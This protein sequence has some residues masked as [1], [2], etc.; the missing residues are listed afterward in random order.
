MTTLADLG[1]NEFGMN[2]LITGSSSLIGT[3]D[4]GSVSGSKI[5][6][7]RI[8]SADGKM[9]IDLTKREIILFDKDNIAKMLMG[10]QQ[11]GF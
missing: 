11:G 8:T 3:Q 4:I 5:V 1:Y 9:V 10:F 6:G 2:P 7:G